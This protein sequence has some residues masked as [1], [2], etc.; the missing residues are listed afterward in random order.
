MRVAL[1]V[2]ATMFMVYISVTVSAAHLSFVSH[3]SHHVLMQ[4]PTVLSVDVN[5]WLHGDDCSAAHGKLEK[6]LL[7]CSESFDSW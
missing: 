2:A 6:I 1:A 7:E 4:V 5:Y 3:L